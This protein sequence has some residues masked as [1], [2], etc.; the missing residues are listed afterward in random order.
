M[1]ES[2]EREFSAKEA[3][4]KIDKTVKEW[5][6]DDKAGKLTDT[7]NN[8]GSKASGDKLLSVQD[9]VTYFFTE[10][11]I[12]RAVE[13]VSFEIGQHEV[14]GL[15][16]ETGCGKSVTAL[17]LIQL[18]RQPGKIMGGHVYFKGEDLLAKSEVEMRKIR[19]KDITMIFQDPMNSLNPVFSVERQLNEVFMLHQKDELLAMKARQID[20][21]KTRSQEDVAA[22]VSKIANLKDALVNN[23]QQAKELSARIRQAEGKLKVESPV[24]RVGLHHIIRLRVV[25][26]ASITE[27]VDTKLVESELVTNKE[28]LKN[29]DVE[30]DRI[31][32]ELQ[33]LRAQLK[34]PS[35]RKLNYYCT[36]LSIKALRD[37]KI[38]TPEKIIKSYP[39]ELSGGMRQRVMIAMGLACNPE[40][41]IAD[42]P[43]TALD[44]TIQAQILE[45]MRELKKK[46]K[47]SILIITHDLGTIAEMCDRVAIMYSGRIV[48]YGDVYKL[49]KD[50]K[51]PYTRGLLHSIP[52]LS[53]KTEKLPII[54][55]NVPNLI[56]PPSG[57]R[58]HPRCAQR[59]VI[60]DKI[61]PPLFEVADNY[62]VACFLYAKNASQHYDQSA[63]APYDPMHVKKSSE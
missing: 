19:G 33:L 45:L 43:T 21:W 1:T 62:Q 8:I 17:S 15:V 26:R 48:E 6:G 57:C 25:L 39:H 3:A 61:L 37:V 23:K 9:L 38:H 55:G 56:Y 47:T 10:E 46:Y 20:Q 35:K 30:I 4:D 32:V 60:C 36:L 50:P 51:H 31:K 42:E 34:N 2:P 49:F 18:V 28:T 14:L 53:V 22:I 13:G 7:E 5:K 11:G 58:F 27:P 63:F 24:M 44:V 54:P 29:I 52:D 40:L 12:V 41:L 16:G 59:M